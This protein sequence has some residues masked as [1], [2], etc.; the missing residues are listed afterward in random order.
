L[1]KHRDAQFWLHL[2]TA[3]QANIQ[4]KMGGV[5]SKPDPSVQMEVIGAGYS[6]TG[7]LSVAIALEKLLNK[8]VVHGGSR[9]FGGEGSTVS[10]AL[11]ETTPAVH[12]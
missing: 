10:I 9:S 3:Q 2:I 7:T 4:V 6:R 11:L 12:N 1:Q 8:P 5:P